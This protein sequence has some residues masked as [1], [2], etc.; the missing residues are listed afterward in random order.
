MTKDAQLYE[1]GFLLAPE[2]NEEEVAGAVGTIRASVEE[3]GGML[4][5]A[6]DPKLQRLAYPVNKKTQAYFGALYFLLS[7]SAIGEVDTAMKRNTAVLRHLVAKRIKEE[8]RPLLRQPVIR[9]ETPLALNTPVQEPSAAREEKS[10]DVEAIDKK[11]D[12]ILGE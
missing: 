9:K 12:E 10:V 6:T 11:L 5:S 1:V 8:P 3:S 7:P 2:L 4:E